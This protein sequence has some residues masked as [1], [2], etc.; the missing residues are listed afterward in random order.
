M[1]ISTNVL[2]A[3]KYDYQWI[4]GY[5]DYK[6]FKFRLS[7]LDFNNGVVDTSYYSSSPDYVLDFGGSFIDNKQG[8]IILH[9]NN[10][11]VKD[12]TGAIISGDSLITPTGSYR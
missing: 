11:V 5:G 4:F 2:S 8:E 7:L 3:Q 1:Y 10:C 12:T 9:T 6:E